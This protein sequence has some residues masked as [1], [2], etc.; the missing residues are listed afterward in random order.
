MAS[1]VSRVDPSAKETPML[2][3]CLYKDEDVG[4]A[5]IKILIAG[6]FNPLFKDNYA[7]TVIFYLARDGK[8][9]ITKY[10][11]DTYDFNLN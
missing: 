5:M 2:A 6:G 1:I 4:L 10:L 8:L 11:V 9:A 3:A 7:Q